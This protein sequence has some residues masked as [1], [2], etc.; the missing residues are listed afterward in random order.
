[1]LGMVKRLVLSTL[2][3][4][5]Y[6]LVKLD[7]TSR[8]ASAAVSQP[9]ASTAVSIET[10]S[11]EPV[12][13]EPVAAAPP[14]Q[15]EIPIRKFLDRDALGKVC[16]E[17]AQIQSEDEWEERLRA[18][19]AAIAFDPE[20][21]ALLDSHLYAA[22]F[23]SEPPFYFLRGAYRFAKG[24]LKGAAA[25]FAEL[26]ERHKSRLGY[27]CLGRTRAAV[28]DAA[29]ARAG[30]T[31]GLRHCPNDLMLTMEI[32]T[33][34]FR[35]G[36]AQ[37][38]NEVSAHVRGNLA[39]QKARVT[40]L[41]SEVRE[42]IEKRTMFRTAEGDI[43]TDEFVKTVWQSYFDEFQIYSGWQRGNAWLAGA[44][45]DEIG[46]ILRNDPS[47]TQAI[48]FGAFCAAPNHTLAKMFPSVEFVGLDR[49]EII[50]DLNRV[51]FPAPNAT[52]VAGDIIDFLDS[53]DLKP[54]ALLFHSRTACLCYPE[55]LKTFYQ[56]C[57]HKKVRYIWMYEICSM[58]R[59][60]LEFFDQG[61]MPVVSIAARSIMIIHDYVKL[62]ENA[63]YEIVSLTHPFQTLLL[64]HIE[65][66]GMDNLF[67]LAKLK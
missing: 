42:A 2:E 43:Y 26:C 9:E 11:A 21:A 60:Y 55:F 46:K 18:L 20:Y 17:L 1:M 40:K 19:M 24:N 58:S 4:A 35:E 44:M 22:L 5:G 51:A 3:R 28:G 37:K 63:G 45:V 62:L 14:P 39:D 23:Q 50:R 36:N 7:A 64:D 66:A 52:Y 59:D 10:V 53:S 33:S 15:F 47:V 49:Q 67:L 30:F 54:N 41:A 48:D 65:D 25:T 8:P 56:K 16:E 12:A 32:A 31:E 29:G 38:A 61:K 6:R 34:Y 27:I 57:A 13:S